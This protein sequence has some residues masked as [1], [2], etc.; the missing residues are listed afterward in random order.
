MW[1]PQNSSP[2]GA[3]S[4]QGDWTDVHGTV[5]EGGDKFYC[6][7]DEDITGEHARKFILAL[8]NEFNEKLIIVHDEA[9]YFQSSTVTELA[10][11]DDIEFVRLP[12]Y[13][14]DL[15]PIENCW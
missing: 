4:W 5:S 2:T 8:S 12:P 6:Q 11:R 7:C 13:P 9:P 3:L 14:P 15:N 10:E 1:F